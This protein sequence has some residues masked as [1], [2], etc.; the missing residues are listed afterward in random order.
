[1]RR[2]LL[3]VA[4][5][6]L[7]SLP[8]FAKSDRDRVAVGDDITIADG[9]TAGDIACA[10]CSV[11]VHGEVQGDIAVFMGRITVD[12]GHEISGD[13][14]GFGTDL[15]LGQ[16]ASVGGDV[17]IA[18]GDVRL[19]S[20]AK[21]HGD[22]KVLPGRFWLVLPFAPLLILAGLIWLV[23]WV[24]RRNRYTPPAYPPNVRRY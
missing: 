13:V 12:A 11:T 5:V 6:L 4:C 19:D 18:A 14:A 23:V 7:I 24:V 2:S 10:F 3:A 9:E 1:M 20:G 16:D 15:V 21:I 17:A 22:Q 8:A